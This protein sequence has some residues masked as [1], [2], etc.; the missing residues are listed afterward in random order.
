ME[1]LEE[2][3]TKTK[4]FINHV[5]SFDNE[6][7][8]ELMNLVQYSLL[9]IIPIV[10]LNK[11]IQNYVP[12]ADDDKGSAE[13]LLEIVLQLAVLLSGM[14]FINRLVTYLPM[15]SG[16]ELGNVNLIHVLLAFLIIVLSLQTKLGEKVEILSNRVIELWSGPKQQIQEQPKNIIR[17][18]QPIS[19]QINTHQQS[20]PTHQP[21]QADNL[22][23]NMD[24]PS[25][26]MPMIQPQQ[27]TQSINTQPDFDSMYQE[28]M[29]ANEGF[30]AF[31][32]VF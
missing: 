29:A 6:T 10:L 17:V 2:T 23:R 12:E 24:M 26:Q 27:Q 8:G 19:Q 7:K 5:F 1:T 14:F 21:S 31:G 28:P 30:S 20:M 18:K 25:T 16:K 32:S 4:G 9:A 3:T 15:Y 11:T 13:I 22:A